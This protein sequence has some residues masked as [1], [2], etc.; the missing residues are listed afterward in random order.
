MAGNLD[1]DQMCIRD[2]AL[3][4]HEITGNGTERMK[5]IRTELQQYLIDK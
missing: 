4:D 3:I 5:Q 1:A 2:R